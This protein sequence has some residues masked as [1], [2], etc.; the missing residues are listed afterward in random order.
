MEGG[1]SL[2]DEKFGSDERAFFKKIDALAA[3]W[4]QGLRFPEENQKSS[5]LFFRNKMA[6]AGR[7]FQ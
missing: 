7:P 4:L 5:F 2:K 6:S 3:H 1:K